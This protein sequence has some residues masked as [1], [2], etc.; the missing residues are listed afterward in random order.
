[1]TGASAPPD[2]PGGWPDLAVQGMSVHEISSRLAG[3]GQDFN[4]RVYP[5]LDQ[6]RQLEAAQP[7]GAS[8]AT[9]REFLSR[10]Y[11]QPLA[12]GTPL[13][14]A[15][16]EALDKAGAGLAGLGD[17]GKASVELYRQADRLPYRPSGD[18]ST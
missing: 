15:L 4:N 18:A 17:R 2:Q 6:I 7:W 9:G 16:H 3:L 11:N 1:V 13:S 5:Q 12:D 14:Q 8:D 10:V